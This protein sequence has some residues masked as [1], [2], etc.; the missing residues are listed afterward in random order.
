MKRTVLILIFLVSLINC[1]GDGVQESR[2][3]TE[4]TVVVEVTRIVTRIVEMTIDRTGEDSVG[5]ELPACIDDPDVTLQVTITEDH[6]IHAQVAG[7]PS[8]TTTT[9]YV[10]TTVG[11]ESRLVTAGPRTIEGDFDEPLD[12]ARWEDSFD[13][14]VRIDYGEG[15]ACQRGTYSP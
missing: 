2:K 11:D 13:W 6:V 4:S 10:L 7:M 14:D 9:S 12:F 5:L 3:E 1:G 15:V 8:Q